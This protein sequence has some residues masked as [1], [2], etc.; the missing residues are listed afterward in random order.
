MSSEDIPSRRYRQTRNTPIPN[1]TPSSQQP[2]NPQH[3]NSQAHSRDTNSNMNY[4]AQPT[5]PPRTPRRNNQA[6]NATN[7]TARE[8]GSKQK[9]R[10]KKNKPQNVTTSPAMKGRD[11]TT[12]PLGSTSSAGLPSK[13]MNTPSNGMFAGPT[14]HASP[15][16][17]ALPIPSF[18]SKSV[19]DSPGLKT[20]R[21]FQ[22]ASL[23]EAESPTPPATLPLGDKVPREESP[24][25][26][27]FRADR[28]EKERARSASSL[29]PALKA[30]GPFPPPQDHRNIQTPPAVGSQRRPSHVQRTSTGGSGMFAMELDGPQSPGASL[31]PAFSTPY[32]DRINAAKK[33]RPREDAQNALERSEALKAYLFSDHTVS[34]PPNHTTTT[35]GSSPMTPNSTYS[36]N[37]QRSPAMA[38]P[39]QQ[40]GFH[41]N[42]ERR[43][44]YQSNNSARASG[45]RQEVT[46]TKTPSMTPDRNTQ[47]AH[48]PINSQIYGNVMNSNHGNFIR[49]SSSQVASPSPSLSYGVSSGN[50]NTDLQGMEN[51]LR[52]LLNLDSS[53]R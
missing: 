52:K 41:Q 23:S 50:K 2:Q 47:F 10:N 37:N 25:D 24:L 17:S 28:A 12:P 5:T 15:A 11:R 6:Q 43:G 45:L 38:P 35:I 44:M 31:G 13:P 29:N 34:P 14:F 16:P 8:N 22:E 39:S 9:S 26:F 4:P 33:N 51:S 53:Q 40:N 1:T 20:T 19:P 42:Q 32:S 30:T 7:S 36:P 49:S 3:L 21:S 27:F 48:S 18:Y 46:P